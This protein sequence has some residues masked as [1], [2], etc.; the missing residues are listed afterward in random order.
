M[1][2]KLTQLFDKLWQQYTQESPEALG[3]YNLFKEHG[4]DNIYN[5]HVAFRTF[6]DSRVNI[7]TLGAFFENLGYEARGEYQFTIKKLFAKH[8]EHATD[9]NQPKVFISE[10]K[11]KEFSPFLQA[12][13]KACIDAISP[14]Q[15]QAMDILYS[16]IHWELDY[17]VYQK[18]LAESEY[19]AWMYVFGYRANH[20]TVSVNHLKTFTS[21]QQI[22]QFLKDNKVTLNTSGGEIK[23]TPQELLE[24]SSTK[25]N[26]VTVKFKQGA[27]EVLNSY[28]EFAQRYPDRNGQLYQGFIAASADKIFESTDI[29]T[30]RLS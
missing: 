3:I 10:L 24:Q 20:F 6:S 13:V 18:L 5:D 1:M 23:G 8:Y 29:N 22:N 21:I 7:T 25:A 9:A 2:S 11:V 17:D 19:A 26:K 14:V 27:Y 4:E 28:Y 30:H 15:L 12:Q 16:G